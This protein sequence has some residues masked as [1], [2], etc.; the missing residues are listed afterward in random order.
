M[1]KHIAAAVLVAVLGGVAYSSESASISVTVKGI[2]N[3]DKHGFFFEIDG[4]IYDIAVNDKNKDDVHK[5]YTD[6]GGDWVTVSGGLHYQEVK[7]GKSYM[8]IYTSEIARLKADRVRAATAPQEPER[9]IV[10]E[11]YVERQGGIDLP[12]VHIRW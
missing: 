8:V 6:L 2:L 11:H 12:L 5:F 10:R 3:E 9:V 7:D 4:M 1:I